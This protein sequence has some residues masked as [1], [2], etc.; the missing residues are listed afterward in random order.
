ML[1]PPTVVGSGFKNF[2][3][4]F[5]ARFKSVIARLDAVAADL[6]SLI[7]ILLFYGRK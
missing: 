6:Y 4:T 5:S 7:S 3:P 2:R 1:G